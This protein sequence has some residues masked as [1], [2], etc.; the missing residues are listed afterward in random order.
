MSDLLKTLK[1]NGCLFFLGFNIHTG[2]FSKD[3]F[4]QQLLHPLY[5][6]IFNISFWYRAQTELL[7][8]HGHIS[9][10]FELVLKVRAPIF[11]A[12]PGP[13]AA[14]SGGAIHI[15]LRQ[16]ITVTLGGVLQQRVGG[17]LLQAIEL[18]ELPPNLVNTGRL[19]LNI[20]ILAP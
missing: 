12:N 8:F 5:F 18:D 17:G 7:L 13:E 19:I 2:S 3:F 20:V 9:S 16:V 1:P 14:V 4:S 10:L 11:G 6:M 15:V